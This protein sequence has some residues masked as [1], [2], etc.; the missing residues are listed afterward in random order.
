MFSIKVFKAQ[1]DQPGFQMW[2]S[3]VGFDKSNDV[4][5]T[6]S[7]SVRAI[8]VTPLKW[9]SL[10]VRLSLWWKLI[11]EKC[12]LWWQRTGP[13]T[14]NIVTPRVNQ[15]HRQKSSNQMDLTRLATRREVNSWLGFERERVWSPNI[16]YE[17]DPRQRTLNTGVSGSHSPGPCSLLPVVPTR[18][19]LILMVK[20]SL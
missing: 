5:L 7:R 19:L 8:E 9:A 10:C 11:S 17:T 6:S 1:V 12:A 14:S 4:M 15:P 20:K 16:R 2:K 13:F 3:I 18:C